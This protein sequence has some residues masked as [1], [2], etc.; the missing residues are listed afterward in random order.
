[1]QYRLVSG[2]ALAG[3]LQSA[4]ASNYNLVENYQGSNFFQKMGF[5]TGGDPTHGYVQYVDQ[6]T[7]QNNGLISL[8]GNTV[9]MGV[10][11]SNVASG[12]GRQSVRVVSQRAYTHMLVT[13]DIEHMP[14]S[15]C[16]VWPAL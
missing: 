5:Y 14:S 13:I 3:L 7:A 16:G 15:I 9:Y 11:H 8:S 4:L 6:G 2:A 10:D 1:M 12:S